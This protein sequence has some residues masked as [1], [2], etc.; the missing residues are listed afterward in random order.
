MN[1]IDRLATWFDQ[2]LT[3]RQYLLLLS[4]LVGVFTAFAAQL[5]QTLIH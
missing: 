3:K 1:P 5:L 4:F 2:H